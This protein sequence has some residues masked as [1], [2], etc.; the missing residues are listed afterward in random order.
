MGKYRILNIGHSPPFFD[1]LLTFK[2]ALMLL[3]WGLALLLSLGL[4]FWG[5]QHPEIFPINYSLVLTLLFGPSAVLGF[6]ISWTSFKSID[7]PE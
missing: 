5:Q 3:T 2:F 7:P 1:F 4:R 6:W